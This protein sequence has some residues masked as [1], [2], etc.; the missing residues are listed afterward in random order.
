MTLSP[1]SP[2]TLAA[3]SVPL[4]SAPGFVRALEA[5][6]ER[7]AESLRDE[8]RPLGELEVAELLDWGEEDERL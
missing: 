7:M 3:V 1:I 6:G 4:S 5:D 8:A 2:H